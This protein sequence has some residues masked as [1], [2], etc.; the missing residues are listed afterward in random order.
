MKSLNAKDNFHIYCAFQHSGDS[1]DVGKPNKEAA[2]QNSG[3]CAPPA[4]AF[5]T[6]TVRLPTV[7]TFYHLKKIFGSS[8]KYTFGKLTKM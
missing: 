1:S 7:N 4:A 2:A 3:A 8:V 6:L 5:I